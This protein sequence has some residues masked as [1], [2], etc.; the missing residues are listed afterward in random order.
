MSTPSTPDPAPLLTL[1]AAA[2]E[3][4]EEMAAAVAPVVEPVVEAVEEVEVS[5][6]VWG[7]S[8]FV[9]YM[10]KSA[11]IWILIKQPLNLP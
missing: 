11:G 8:L 9:L 6:C 10:G 2:E 5:A 4:A 7:V 1:P 3:V